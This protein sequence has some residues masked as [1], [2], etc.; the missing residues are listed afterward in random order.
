MNI[1]VEKYKNE[2]SEVSVFNKI[3]LN[4]I[5][6]EFRSIQKQVKTTIVD[7]LKA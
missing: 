7:L 1:A 2:D 5:D 6:E 4:D 3:I